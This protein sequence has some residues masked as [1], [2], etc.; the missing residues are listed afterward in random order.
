M[1]PILEDLTVGATVALNVLA[2]E[3]DSESKMW[4][5]T[6]WLGLSEVGDVHILDLLEGLNEAGLRLGLVLVISTLR[7]GILQAGEDNPRQLRVSVIF[8]DLLGCSG[9]DD[10]LQV[11]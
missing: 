7:T 10:I 5:A 9:Q 8:V 2:L 1:R 4:Q 11:I 3:D 6:P